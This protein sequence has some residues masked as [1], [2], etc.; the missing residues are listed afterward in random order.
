[1]LGT[2][3]YKLATWFPFSGALLLGSCGMRATIKPY[4]L[5]SSIPYFFSCSDTTI[6]FMTALPVI[7]SWKK[8]LKASFT[9]G[10][11]NPPP[12]ALSVAHIAIDKISVIEIPR[13]KLN[14][15]YCSTPRV[16]TDE[17]PF[18]LLF[19]L[20]SPSYLCGVCSFIYRLCWGR[21]VQLHGCMLR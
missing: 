21:R 5:V 11:I 1:M 8:M 4:L 3:Y 17:A 14:Q 16:L 13:F 20:I 9:H 19:I 6:Y 15:G 18:G 7:R 12:L 10:R 2:R